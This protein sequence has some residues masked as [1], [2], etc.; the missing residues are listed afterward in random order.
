[1]ALR[2]FLAFTLSIWALT[3]MGLAM[4]AANAEATTTGDDVAAEAQPNA[5]RATLPLSPVALETFVDGVWLGQAAAHDLAGA[6]VTVVQNGETI[7]NKGYGYADAEAG[8]AVD[9]ARTLFRIASISK[10]FTWLAVMQLVEQGKLDLDADV[11]GY[12]AFE[13]PAPW[14]QPVTMRQLM[15]H[16]AGY[17]DVVLDLGRRDAAELKPLGEYLANHLPKQVR[18]PGKFSSYSNHSTALAAHIVERVSGQPWSDYIEQNLLEPLGMARTVARHPFPEAL[19]G[20]LA[21]ANY[22]KGGAWSEYDFMHWM[23]YP[24]GMMS[25]TGA[26]MAIYM[27]RLLNDADGLLAPETFAQMLEP[28]YRAFDGARPWRHGFMDHS[29]GDVLIYGHGGDYFAYHSTLMLIPQYR[30]GIFLSFNSEGG[31]AASTHLTQALTDWIVP[32]AR[33][34]RPQPAPDAASQQ[35]QYEGVYARLRRNHSGFAKLALLMAGMELATDND[36]Y[37]VVNGGEPTQFVQIGP[38]RFG[39]RYTNNELFFHRD[40]NDHITHLSFSG[41][42]ANAAERLPWYGT[43]SLH[44]LLFGLLGLLLLIVF[45]AL[46]LRALFAR[47]AKAGEEGLS[48]GLKW[49]IWLCAA[50]MLG[51]LANLAIGL[52]DVTRFYYELPTDVVV[53]RAVLPAFALI[54]M[55][56]AV[57]SLRGVLAGGTGSTVSAGERTLVALFAAATA[58][59]VTLGVYWNLL[60]GWF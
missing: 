18:P 44:R 51:A 41:F 32:E 19:R 52:T 36:G 57:F 3:Q 39:S 25:T 38:D 4:A 21:K 27:K 48:T 56:V 47:W 40:G 26:D 37:L 28:S 22:R 60:N 8:T 54:S 58:L 43:P 59:F 35:A 7:L 2:R 29:R 10:P 23:I 34:Q 20:D 31:N 53:L 9:P 24:A 5:P 13:V 49:G 14:G 46:P 33:P 12:L 6:V 17:E 15:S 45:I 42:A 55:I 30:L 11:N 1:M 50:V 16:S